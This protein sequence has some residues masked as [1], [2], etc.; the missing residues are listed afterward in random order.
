[1]QVR[2]A[3]K[4]VKLKAKELHFEFQCLGSK[5]PEISFFFYHH[6][7]GKKAKAIA[8][9][10]NTNISIVNVRHLNCVFY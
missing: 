3:L 8:H 6:V 2:D 10:Y 1:M 7:Q 4:Q 5:V 9:F